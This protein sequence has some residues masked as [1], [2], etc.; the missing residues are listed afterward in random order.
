MRRV[1]KQVGKPTIDVALNRQFGARLRAPNATNRRRRPKKKPPGGTGRPVLFAVDGELRLPRPRPKPELL[2]QE[3]LRPKLR[4][5]AR[6]E[7][8]PARRL[9]RTPR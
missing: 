8:R 6:P 3:L 5:P 4:R 2:R 9:R 1:E 7:P